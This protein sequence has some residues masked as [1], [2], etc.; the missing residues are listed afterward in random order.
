MDPCAIHRT[1]TGLTFVVLRCSGSTGVN[2][3]A[4]A[5]GARS[6]EQLSKSLTKDSSFREVRDDALGRSLRDSEHRSH[7]PRLHLLPLDPK[8]MTT[9][10][11][12]HKC[13]NGTFLNQRSCVYCQAYDMFLQLKSSHA[14]Q[15][16]NCSHFHSGREMSLFFPVVAAP[17]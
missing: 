14:G 7:K 5:G 12:S 17:D 10:K 13:H 2:G 1:V 3:G 6:V 16:F 4:T 15:Y 11:R 9:S 8:R